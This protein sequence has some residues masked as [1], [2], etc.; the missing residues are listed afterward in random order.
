[1]SDD[2][3]FD[4]IRRAKVVPV[5]T[6]HDVDQARGVARAFLDGGLRMIEITLRTDAALDAIRALAAEFTDLFVG[7]GT[8]SSVSD[9][10]D[11]RAAGASFVV[12]PGTPADLA[13]AL[14]DCGV[15]TVPGAQTA[16]EVMALRTRGFRTIKFFPAEVCGGIGVLKALYGP[17]ADVAFVPTGG[18]SPKNAPDYLALPNVLA[19]GGSWI[20]PQD[21]IA[22]GDW[23]AI[24]ANAAATAQL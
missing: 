19:V 23:E 9:V 13:D 16:S 7:A 1:M 5:V 10:A 6:V 24:R 14:A 15:P 2:S 11:A 8:V 4:A 18:I 17:F 3:V 22:A 21:L 20:A 12:T